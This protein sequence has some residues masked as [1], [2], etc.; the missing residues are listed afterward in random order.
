MSDKPWKVFEREVARGFSKWV[1]D[2][3]DD[4]V[5]CRQALLGRMVESVFGDLAVN[6]KCDPRWKQAGSWFM[7]KFMVDAKNRKAF[8][9]SGLLTAPLHPFW[10][11]WEKLEDDAARAGSKTPLIVVLDKATRARL[12]AFSDV[13]MRAFQD[14]FG[15]PERWMGVRGVVDRESPDVLPSKARIHKVVFMKFE[16]FFKW[17]SPYGLGCPG[18]AENASDVPV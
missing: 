10:A 8:S 14:L 17:V 18:R 9:L 7:S 2:G 15:F 4:K 6:P 16:D 3:D 1:T 13:A 11:W 5:I 12:L